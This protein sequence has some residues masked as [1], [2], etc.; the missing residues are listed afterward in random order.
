VENPDDSAIQQGAD[1]GTGAPGDRLTTPRRLTVSVSDVS[2]PVLTVGPDN[3]S[4]AVV[5][6][7][8][9]PG[10]GSEWEDLLGRVGDFARAVAP[11]MPGYAGA[12]KPRDFDYTVDGYARHLG[13]LLNELA[14]E[15]AHLVMHDF[16][17]PW[18]LQWAVSNPEAFASATMI[19]SGVWVDYRHYHLYGRIWRTPLL[20]ELFMATANRP[21]NGWIVR[22]ENPALSRE[23]ANRLYDQLRPWPTKRAILRL[24]RATPPRSLA[25]RSEPMR[26]LDPPA[27]VVWG[28]D[29]AYIPR[30]MADRQRLSFPSVHIELLEG[31]GHWCFLEDPERV[32]SAVVPFLREQVGGHAPVADN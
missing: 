22:R 31:L 30:E 8:G 19:N 20:G 6:V 14:I 23:R 9:N 10:A 5:F 15:R 3:A 1:Q 24:Y 32:A 27:L 11:D 29:D 28:A 2:S 17:G 26:A 12:D 18:A 16:G 21:V 4:E 7:H 25:S 13:G